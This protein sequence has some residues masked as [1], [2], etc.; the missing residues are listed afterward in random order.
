MCAIFFI[1]YR[2]NEWFIKKK[3]VPLHP[4]CVTA[5]GACGPLKLR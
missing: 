1:F 3:F 2:V 4:I 5:G